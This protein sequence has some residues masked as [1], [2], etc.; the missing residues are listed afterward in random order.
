MN[1]AMTR[2]VWFERKFVL[3]L[4]ADA[5][6]DLI[7]RIRGTPARLEERV[8]GLDPATL[9]RRSGDAWSIQENVGHLGDLESLWAGR[10]DDFLQGLDRLRAADL[11]NR[12]TH[13]ARHNEDAI[14]D[15]LASFRRQRFATVARLDSI[16]PEDLA[17]TALHPRL[18]QPMTIV[19]HFFFV[20]E[21]DD[22]HLAAIGE[23]IR[24][25]GGG[26]S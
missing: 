21:H 4:P 3:G 20:A 2:R 6:P 16:G 12:K 5:F 17:R 8:R 25:F 7:E 18:G 19:D 15:L 1:S 22:H 23:R 24:A 26:R 10:L 14:E 9:V 11:Q 13:E